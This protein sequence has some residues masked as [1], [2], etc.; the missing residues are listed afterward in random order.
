MRLDLKVPSYFFYPKEIRIMLLH[1][2]ILP[3][4]LVSLSNF[5]A[6]WQFPTLL[7]EQRESK[8]VPASHL[9]LVREEK[10][11]VVPPPSASLPGW[12]HC[13]CVG[14]APMH[15]CVPPG[16]HQNHQDWCPHG[17]APAFGWLFPEAEEFAGHGGE[18]EKGSWCWDQ[19]FVR[20]EQIWSHHRK[21]VSI[22]QPLGILAHGST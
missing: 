18:W 3:S 5:W 12:H 21:V 10:L 16:S 2:S 6:Q 19:H 4:A 22:R 14:T 15:T 13:P 8:Q 20:G 11:R 7:T 1:F 9:W 17:L